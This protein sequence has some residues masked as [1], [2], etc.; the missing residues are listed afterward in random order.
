MRKATAGSVL[1]ALAMA[2]CLL[3]GCRRGGEIVVYHAERP[4][5]PN[6]LFGSASPVL[7]PPQ[8]HAEQEFACHGRALD[9]SFFPGELHYYR[10]YTRDHRRSPHADRF[11]RYYYGLREGVIHR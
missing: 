11:D 2:A 3:G 5:N 1:L 8:W 10:E 4:P 9:P 7:P 6:F